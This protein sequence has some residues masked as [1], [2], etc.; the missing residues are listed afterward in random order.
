MDILNVNWREKAQN[1]PVVNYL[2][3]KYIF[4]S[5]YSKQIKGRKKQ[6]KSASKPKDASP[7][8]LVESNPQDK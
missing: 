2:F 1:D 6:P 5:D 8:V 3:G 7:D 4:Q